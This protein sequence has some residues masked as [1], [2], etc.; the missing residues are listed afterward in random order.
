VRA[1]GGSGRRDISRGPLLLQRFSPNPPLRLAE[2]TLIIRWPELWLIL[3]GPMASAI[4]NLSSSEASGGTQGIRA[5]SA[6][7]TGGIGGRVLWLAAMR[8]SGGAVGTERGGLHSLPL[9]T[10]PISA[11]W[12]P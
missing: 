1:P 6:L 7:T 2:N 5:A 4:N 12:Q 9:T 8:A 11:S 3:A 10:D